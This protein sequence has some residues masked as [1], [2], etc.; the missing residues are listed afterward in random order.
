MGDD[1]TNMSLDSRA[2]PE[3]VAP[4]KFSR[5]IVTV[6]VLVALVAGGASVWFIQQRARAGDPPVAHES[7]SAPKYLVHLDEFTV[8]L[9][10]PEETHF[11]R[12]A[13]DL[14]AD[15]PLES[16]QK[17][18]SAPAAPVPQIRDTILAVLTV[19]KASELL[20]PEGKAR[21]KKTLI[22]ALNRDVPEIGVREIYFTEFLVQR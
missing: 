13:I 3:V 1:A 5:A 15:R 2:A 19:C 16:P 21:L 11:L 12:V 20:N 4:Q 7:S 10:D 8:N 6:T 18:K 9:A 17:E 22:D 14:G